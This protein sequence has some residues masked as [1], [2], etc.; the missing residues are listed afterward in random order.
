MVFIA[1]DPVS[2]Y[3]GMEVTKINSRVSFTNHD[4][5]IAVHVIEKKTQ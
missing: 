4:G 3:A 5:V 1:A 2:V